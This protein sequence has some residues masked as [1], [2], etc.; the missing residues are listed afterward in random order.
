MVTNAPAAEGASRSV[1]AALS[2]FRMAGR[3]LKGK[4]TA[5]VVPPVLRNVR[6][7]QYHFFLGQI[8][9]EKVLSFF[10]EENGDERVWTV[11][12]PDG[13]RKAI[14]VNTKESNKY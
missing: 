10:V 13:G 5:G 7:R 12:T 9:V 11:T 14:V 6:C 4:R 1:P 2:G 3:L 8:W